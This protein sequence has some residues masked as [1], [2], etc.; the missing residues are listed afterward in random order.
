MK[1][2]LSQYHSTVSRRDFL[3]M[4]G[5]G[6]VGMA[7]IA[8]NPPRLHDLDEVMASP[9]AVLKRPAYVKEVEKPTVE[10][11]WNMMNRFDYS[12]VMWANG[13]RKALGP[14]QYDEVFQ[15]QAENRIKWIKE[16][17][18]GLCLAG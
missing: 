16:A 14:D 8:I 7:A 3:K 2:Q 9:L 6:G 13:L 18:A 11:D 17:G 15:V 12:E 5:L 1:N 4:L 10:I